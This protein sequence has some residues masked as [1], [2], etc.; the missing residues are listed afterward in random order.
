MPSC[1]SLITASPSPSR[2][3]SSSSSSSHLLDTHCVPRGKYLKYFLPCRRPPPGHR[4]RFTV[5]LGEAELSPRPQSRWR[6]P[7][8]QV[9]DADAHTWGRA[10]RE[11]QDC[12]ELLCRWTCVPWEPPQPIP[13]R[14]SEAA[15]GAATPP[16]RPPHPALAR[17]PHLQEAREHYSQVLHVSDAAERLPRDPQDLV[18]AQISKQ[19]ERGTGVNHCRLYLHLIMIT[20]PWQAVWGLFSLGPGCTAFTLF[21]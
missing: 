20:K 13:Q 4:P 14:V 11:D 5:T 6:Q 21:V 15:Q 3:S 2:P 12:V 17:E 8:T 9:W 18:L 16:C 1:K 7:R 10:A 19:E